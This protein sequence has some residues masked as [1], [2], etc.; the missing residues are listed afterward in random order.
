MPPLSYSRFLWPLECRV[1]QMRMAIALG[2]LATQRGWKVRFTMAASLV[3]ALEAAQRQGWLKGVLH[4][5]VN[6]YRL[7]VIDEIGYPPM[8][9]EQANLFFEAV[10]KRYERHDHPH[11]EPA[12]RQLGPSLRG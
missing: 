10:T 11:L 8:G 12:V 4:R 7:L 9:R 2:Y 5:A 3:M 1:G 6:I